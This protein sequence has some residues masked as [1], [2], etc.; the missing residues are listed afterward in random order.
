M[1]RRYALRDDQWHVI[2][3]MLPA[4]VDTVGWAIRDTRV[5]VD[6]VL[7]RYRAGI[8]WRDLQERFG[9]W[10]N[11]HKRFSSWT[12]S[13]IWQAVFVHACD[14]EDA[15]VV[16]VDMGLDAD[17]RV[18]EPLAIVDKIAVISPKRIRTRQRSYDKHP[19]G[20]RHLVEDFFA[21][22][23]QFRAVATRYD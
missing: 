17:A 20:A 8:A 7:Y 19:Y 18:L 16:L 10:K 9:G 6:F 11:L 13:S 1:G 5:F 23:K 12:Q 3:D 2:R 21:G 15:N 4:R 14:L 22:I